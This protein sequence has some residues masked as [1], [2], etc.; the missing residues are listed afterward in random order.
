TNDSLMKMAASRRNLLANI[1]H[2]LGTPVMLLHSYMQALEAGILSESD[3]KKYR[4][5]VDQNIKILNR[6]IDDLADLSHLEEGNTSLSFQSVY[7]ED[8]LEKLYEKFTVDVQSYNRKFNRVEPIFAMH[9]YTCVLD[10][11]RM[12]QVFGNVLSNAV[13][14]TSEQHGVIT[15]SSHLYEDGNMMVVQ[16]SDNGTGIDQAQIPYLFD[17]FYQPKPVDASKEK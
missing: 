2:E 9:A 8:W 13:K 12:N 4:Q 6:L 7:V 1:A 17:R 11:E 14:H 3:E 16:I 5:T 10:W 15:L